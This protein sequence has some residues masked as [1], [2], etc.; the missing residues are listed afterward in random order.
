MSIVIY[1][2]KKDC[3]LIILKTIIVIPA[4]GNSKGIKKKNLINFS[5][6]PLLY[7]TIAQAQKTKFKKYIYV[8]SENEEI[9]NFSKSLGV[10]TIRRPL[11][12]SK[13]NSSSESAIKHVLQQLEFSPSNIIFLQ[14][15]S[16]LRFPTDIHNAFNKFRKK[17]LDSLF[18]CHQAEDYFDIWKKKKNI[19]VPLTIDYRKRK[20]R[21]FFRE[22]HVCQNGSIY[23]FKT[24]LLLKK[25]NRIGGKINVFKMKEWQS[26]QIDAMEQKKTVEYLFNFYLKKFYK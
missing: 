20:P 18:S 4:R 26:F 14:A 10:N 2:Y 19:Y 24:Y 5:G 15:T 13:D 25:N 6:K 22:E 17:K 21:Q 11:N 12:L 8:S 7:W 9:I 1:E 16:P 23:I 3:E